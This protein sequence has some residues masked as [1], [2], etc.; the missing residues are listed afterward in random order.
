M[1][2]VKILLLLCLVPIVFSGCSAAE[3]KNV[4]IPEKDIRGEL[5]HNIVTIK[6]SGSYEECIELRPGLVFDYEFDA[7][8]FVNFNIHYH[9]VT[10][11]HYPVS[12]M[13]VKFGKGVIDPGMHKFYTEEQENYCMMWENLN[14]GPIKVSYRCVLRGK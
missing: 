13:G 8:D 9:A 7:S 10:G 4:Q 14:D 1:K 11:V 6:E 12:S 5:V 2:Y 3:T